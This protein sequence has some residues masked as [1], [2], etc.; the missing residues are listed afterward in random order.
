MVGEQPRGVEYFPEPAFHPLE[1][2]PCLGRGPRFFSPHFWNPSHFAPPLR[3]VST[4]WSSFFD[5]RLPF[6]R[7]EGKARRFGVTTF[8]HQGRTGDPP[9]A[10]KA[11]SM[12]IRADLSRRLPS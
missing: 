7:L 9:G 2:L 6:S 5:A 4:R 10:G 3:P 12:L 1:E 11:G 8:G